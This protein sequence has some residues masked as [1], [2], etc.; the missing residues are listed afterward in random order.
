M[1]P[2]HRAQQFWRH[3]DGE[4]MKREVICNKE[5]EKKRQEQARLCCLLT[6]ALQHVYYLHCRQ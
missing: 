2:A 5:E 1:Q 3:R 6:I 4:D